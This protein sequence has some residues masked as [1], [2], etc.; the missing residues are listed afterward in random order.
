[1][2]F[3]LLKSPLVL[4]ALTL[5]LLAWGVRSTSDSPTEKPRWV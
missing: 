1:M 2:T 5:G 3:L 4:F